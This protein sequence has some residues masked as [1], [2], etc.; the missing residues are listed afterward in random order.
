MLYLRRMLWKHMARAAR[1]ARVGYPYRLRERGVTIDPA[2]VSAGV[3]EFAP[4]YEGAVSACRRGVGAR[5]SLDVTSSK[6]AGARAHGY[7]AIDE[8]G[9]VVEV[10]VGEQRAA[11]DATAFFRRAIAATGAV[12]AAVTTDRAAAYLRAAGCSCVVP[13]CAILT[14]RA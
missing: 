12:P 5:R 7:R 6:V 11:D 10:C 3:R 1:E 2:S 14:R 9:Q 4:R 13:G 8:R